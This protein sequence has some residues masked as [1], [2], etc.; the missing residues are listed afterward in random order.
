MPGHLQQ[1]DLLLHRGHSSYLCCR[2][3]DEMTVPPVENVQVKLAWDCEAEGGGSVY[4][5]SIT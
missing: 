4:R 2:Q 3:I 5:V 1:C